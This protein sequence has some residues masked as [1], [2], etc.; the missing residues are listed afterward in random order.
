M[1][2]EP[3]ERYAIDCAIRYEKVKLTAQRDLGFPFR[4]KRD[5]MRAGGSLISDGISQA[6]ITAVVRAQN[7]KTTSIPGELVPRADVVRQAKAR[8]RELGWDEG[9]L[10][11]DVAPHRVLIRPGPGLLRARTS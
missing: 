11:F 5:T 3:P 1:S 9:F 4:R 8:A 10:T 6:V 2:A 7:G